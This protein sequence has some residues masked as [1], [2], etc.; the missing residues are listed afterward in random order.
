VLP[1]FPAR[2]GQEVAAGPGSPAP[3][4][5]EHSIE[6]ARE[7]GMSADE[8]DALVADGVLKTASAR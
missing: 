2:F 5:G 6:I 4:F 7:A 3:R 8:V 1:G